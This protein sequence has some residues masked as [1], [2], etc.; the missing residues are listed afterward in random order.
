MPLDIYNLTK[1]T[2]IILI[3]HH[4]KNYQNDLGET[5]ID[6]QPILFDTLSSKLQPWK[7]E[8]LYKFFNIKWVKIHK[9]NKI[10]HKT[11]TP[12]TLHHL[13]NHAIIINR[14]MNKEGGHNGSSTFE[15]LTLH[16]DNKT[17]EKLKL[18]NYAMGMENES[19]SMILMKLSFRLT[20]K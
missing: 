11:K 19:P 7:E 20:S 4:G 2:I 15:C 16:L 3:L 5:L 8:M 14:S 13:N 1:H 9:I 17:M 10:S 6:N 18:I 12:L